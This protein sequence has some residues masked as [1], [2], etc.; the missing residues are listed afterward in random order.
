MN[1][2]DMAT[3]L[4]DILRKKKPAILKRWLDVI[5]A[6]Y[7]G[8]AAAFIKG[9]KN[10]FTGPMGYTIQ[11]GLEGLFDGLIDEA[12]FEEIA[13]FLE[14]IIKIR[15]V[16]DFSP[17]QAVAFIFHLKKI[18]SEESQN[19]SDTRGV[20]DTAA[21]T[22]FELKIDTL[23]L[24]SFD[25][26]MEARDKVYQLKTNE[27]NDMVFR[28]LQKERRSCEMQE[29]GLEQGPNIETPILK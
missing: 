20:V 8:E 12:P 16:Q 7:S 6:T 24:I 15:A 2:D 28:L 1:G 21:L 4:N 25:L 29:Q 9:Q 13:P 19:T 22:A 10:Q 18:I 17:S 3:K 26:Y 11:E 5:S 23:A 27:S 14:S